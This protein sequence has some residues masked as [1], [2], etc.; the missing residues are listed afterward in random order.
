MVIDLS[1][2]AGPEMT[3]GVIVGIVVAVV[4]VFILLFVVVFARATGR[5]CFAGKQHY[6]YAVTKK[7]CKLV[8][9]M[10]N[11]LLNTFP[12]LPENVYTKDNPI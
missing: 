1:V 5:W 3:A 12:I 2:V 9:A 4:A 6:A 11:E 8:M 10:S 7:Y